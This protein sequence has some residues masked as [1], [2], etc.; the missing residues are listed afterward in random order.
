MSSL[1]TLA[2]RSVFVAGTDT[3]CGKTWV[4][5][6]MIRAL[7]ARGV[8]VTGMKPVAAGAEQK[9]EGWRNDDALALAAAA[10][11]DPPYAAINPYCLP[12]ATSPHLAARA[13]GMRIEPSVV[14]AAYRELTRYVD[15]VVVEGA[16][17]WLAPIEKTRNGVLTMQ[18]IA[19]ALH[20]PVVLVVGMRLGCINHALLTQDAIRASGLTLAGW[21]GN[22]VEAGFDADGDYRRAL[23][24]LLLAP[25]I[26]V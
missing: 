23:G 25:E 21:V 16:G 22:R 26:P 14:V 6:R 2:L 7:A 8:R 18:D 5:V 10:N 13:A 1:A 20:L 12:L 15:V 24:E 3:G 11:V 19:L 9:P 17:G 4:A